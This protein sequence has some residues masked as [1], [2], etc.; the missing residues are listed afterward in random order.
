M[1]TEIPCVPN[2]KIRARTQNLRFKQAG[3]ACRKFSPY[4]I[5]M[6]RSH[7]EVLSSWAKIFLPRYLS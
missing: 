1:E 5:L 4:S 7:A 3:Q 6:I 2:F